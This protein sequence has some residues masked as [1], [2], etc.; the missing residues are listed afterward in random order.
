VRR[1]NGGEGTATEMMVSAFGNWGLGY[2]ARGGGGRQSTQNPRA[3]CPVTTRPTNRMKGRGVGDE[4][5][6][7]DH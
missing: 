3:R 6:E 4:K 7:P 5:V 2:E 1:K